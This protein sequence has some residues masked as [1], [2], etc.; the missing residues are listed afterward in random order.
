M[1]I[2]KPIKPM[3]AILEEKP[4]EDKSFIYENKFDGNRA[5]TEINRGKVRFYSRNGIDYSRRYAP[6]FE[7]LKK[8]KFKGVLDG[9]VVVLDS[10]GVS[11][12]QL[13]QNYMKTGK[14]PLVYYVFDILKYNGKNLKDLSLMER[15]KY[16]NKAIKDS[17]HVRKTRVFKNNGLA[18][19]D[20]FVK[21]GHEGIMAK[22]RDGKYIEG[23]RNRNWLKF[24]KPK[25]GVFNIIGFTKEKENRKKIGALH[26]AQ[27]GRY[28]GNVG[29]GFNEQEK[30]EYFKMFDKIRTDKLNIKYLPKR[31]S[32]FLIKKK[33]KAEIKFIEK[34]NAGNLRHPAFVKLIK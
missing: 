13:L 16:L 2:S 7:E 3:L 14:G 32:G 27:N 30:R 33:Y 1:K 15:K 6:I 8:M 17:A 26:L 29:T 9:E 34:T 21:L 4:Y 23:N 22:K 20:K 31:I 11:K 28:V 25:S 18:L 19:L 10:K 5:I 12:F 24:K